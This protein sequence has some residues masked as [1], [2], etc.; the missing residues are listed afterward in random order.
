MTEAPEHKF[1]ALDQLTMTHCE[2]QHKIFLMTL[3][4]N[5]NCTVN[6]NAICKKILMCEYNTRWVTQECCDTLV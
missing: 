3:S 4:I 2:K 5:R 6:L 1:E